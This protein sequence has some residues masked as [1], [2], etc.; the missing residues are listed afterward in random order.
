MYSVLTCH[1]IAKHT[2]IYVR[3]LWFN[4]NSTGNAEY[5]RKSLTVV[6]QMLLCGKCYE[7]VYT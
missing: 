5:L 6:F 7:N 2:E 3:Y 1:N 4:V